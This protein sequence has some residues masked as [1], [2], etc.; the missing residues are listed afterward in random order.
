MWVLVPPGVSVVPEQ[1][2]VHG[3]RVTVLLLQRGQELRATLQL[4]LLQLLQ[5]QQKT[6][7]TEKQTPNSVSG[8][9][10][11]DQPWLVPIPLNH[12]SFVTYFLSDVVSA[13]LLERSTFWPWQ[14]ASIHPPSFFCC[15]IQTLDPHYLID[16]YTPSRFTFINTSH[17]LIIKPIDTVKH[18]W[19]F[20][21]MPH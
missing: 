5:L 16:S 18:Q 14:A 4:L 17:D 8:T 19:C 6:R 11:C 9:I 10:R 2:V 1:T 20:G 12:F 13:A 3:A 21:D 7:A 15:Y